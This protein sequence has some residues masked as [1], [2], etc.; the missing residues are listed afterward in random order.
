MGWFV[1]L[2]QATICLSLGEAIIL[3]LIRVGGRLSAGQPLDS[4]AYGVRIQA[5]IGMASKLLAK[6]VF[7]N[8]GTPTSITGYFVFF[9][10][11]A[12]FWRLSG[13]ISF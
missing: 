4:Q 13:D 8:P 12:D 9:W 6:V 2:A 7:P 5:T 3:E 11:L 1:E 10:S